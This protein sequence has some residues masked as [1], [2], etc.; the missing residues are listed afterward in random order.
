[1]LLHIVPF[2]RCK[3]IQH[4]NSYYEGDEDLANEIQRGV[5]I[6]KAVPQYV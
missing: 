1:M 6:G 2:V 5:Y 4:T 3:S